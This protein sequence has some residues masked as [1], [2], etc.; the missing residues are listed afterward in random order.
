MVE[1]R[2]VSKAYARVA[3]GR[4]HALADASFRIGQGEL[5]ILCG[6]MGAGKSTLLRLISG[7]ERPSQ[8]TVLVDGTDLG[9]LGRRG[10]ARLRR[11]LAVIP[12]EPRLV[13]ERTAFGN[14]AFVLQALGL[15][16]AEARARALAALRQVGLAAKGNALPAE[17]AWSERQRLSIARALAVA[18]RLLLADEPFAVV[19][20][21]VTGEMVELFRA[22]NKEGTTVVLATRVARLAR[23]LR[24]RAFM[25]DGGRVRVDEPPHAD[26]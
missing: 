9:T 14:V 3:G 25:L 4:V 20:D 1:F 6:P 12:Q 19:D 5:A 22:M 11:R 23:D 7:E 10:L 17:L 21:A 26:A 24:A 8:G 15:P 2:G 18:P 16:R 13:A